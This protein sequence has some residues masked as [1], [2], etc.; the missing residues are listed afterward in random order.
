MS[1][2][3]PWVSLL[4]VLFIGIASSV[5]APPCQVITR[6]AV[7]VPAW[8]VM[9]ISLITARISCLRSTAVVVGR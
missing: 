3:V 9:A 1:S 7:L 2:L 6:S 5:A 4:P 8:T